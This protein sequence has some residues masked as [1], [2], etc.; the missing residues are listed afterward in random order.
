MGRSPAALLA[1][2]V[3]AEMT[4][5]P[6]SYRGSRMMKRA[7]FG[8]IALGLMFVTL[9]RLSLADESTIRRPSREQVRSQLRPP[10]K[11]GSPKAAVQ[12]VF[13]VEYDLPAE[14]DLSVTLLDLR[15]MPLRTFHLAKGQPGTLAGKNKITIWDGTDSNGQEMP[16]GEYMAALSF[17]Y[18]D[19]TVENKRFRII[20]P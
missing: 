11:F 13:E 20:K 1:S 9:H 5:L 4:K 2:A 15:A 6:V 19:G 17:Q 8:L 18:K 16:A 10:A 7:L 12:E 14:A 3:A